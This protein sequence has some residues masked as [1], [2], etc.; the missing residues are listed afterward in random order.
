MEEWPS[1]SCQWIPN[2]TNDIRKN[3]IHCC[4]NISLFL[5]R[6]SFFHGFIGMATTFF[7]SPIIIVIMMGWWGSCSGGRCCSRS[8]LLL[9]NTTYSDSN[10]TKNLRDINGM[11]KSST[12]KN[13]DMMD[14][15]MNVPCDMSWNGRRVTHVKLLHGNYLMSIHKCGH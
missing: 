15:H 6:W 14:R 1:L 4:V 8:T 5:V 9:L 13:C 10:K 12:M 7:L 2:I 11:E 3:T